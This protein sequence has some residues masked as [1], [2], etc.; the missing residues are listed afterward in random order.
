MLIGEI[1]RKTGLTK[2]T[3]RFYEKQG[4]IKTMVGKN[5]TNNYKTYTD[6]ILN[7]LLLIK[8]IKSFGFTLNETAR[9]L[10]SIEINQASCKTV[11]KHLQDKIQLLDKKI[12][13]LQAIRRMM[14]SLS[15]DCCQSKGDDCPALAN[16]HQELS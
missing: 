12:I 8:R 11:S 14:T 5:S 13:E 15:E 2:D 7:R 4:L 9:L 6:D 16:L 1:V 10:D 3:I